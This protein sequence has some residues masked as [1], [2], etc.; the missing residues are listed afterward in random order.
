MAPH[1]DIKNR[2]FSFI[3]HWKLGIR[4]FPTLALFFSPAYDTSTM[5]YLF[6]ILPFTFLVFLGA[7][8]ISPKP[9]DPDANRV[10]PVVQDTVP[11]YN[12]ELGGSKNQPIELQVEPVQE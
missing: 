2:Y 7:G 6:L 11:I 12:M 9:Q 4:N 5:K 8:C 3:G 10:A 1:G